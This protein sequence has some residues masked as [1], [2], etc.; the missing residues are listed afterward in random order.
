MWSEE[1]EVGLELEFAI[2]S[3]APE[4]YGDGYFGSS[5]FTR[6]SVMIGGSE[7][8]EAFVHVLLWP[9][10]FLGVGGEFFVLVGISV[11]MK[12]VYRFAPPAYSDAISRDSS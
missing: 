6:G 8:V 7:G 3:F 9:G 1:C 11:L 2:E 5:S 4:A 12:A 10:L